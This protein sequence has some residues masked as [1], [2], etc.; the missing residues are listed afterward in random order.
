LDPNVTQPGL[1]PTIEDVSPT[2]TAV[3]APRAVTAGG[4]LGLR[5]AVALVVV[6]L[7][8]ATSAAGAWFLAGRSGTS[9]LA[10]WV[11]SD[12]VAYVE[13][14]LDLPGDQRQQLGNFLAHFP[15]FK[16]Q[17]NLDEKIAEA[18]DRAIRGS[19]NDRHDYSTEVQPWFGGEVAASVGPL[20]P[21]SSSASPSSPP[22]MRYLVLVSTHDRAATEAWV[23]KVA[24]EAPT[25]PTTETYKGVT[26]RTVAAGDHG[27]AS[28]AVLDRVLLVGDPASVKAS[29]DTGG[30]AGLAANSHFSAASDRADG[31]HL[32]FGWMNVRAYVDWSMRVA[33]AYGAP[34][35]RIDPALTDFVPGWAVGD[36]RATNGDALTGRAVAPHSSAIPV[37]ARG[38]STLPAH[39][40]S[41][42]LAFLDVHDT[43]TLAKAALDRWRSVP[44][45]TN[46]MKSVDQ[47]LAALGGEDAAIGWLGEAAIAVLP[48]GTGATAGAL[49]AAT[50]RDKAAA[51]A[52]QIRNLLVLGGPSLGLSSRDENHN[53][54]TITILT[55]SAGQDGIAGA[56][57]PS[58]LAFAVRDDLVVAGTPAFVRAVLDTRADASLASI[59]RFTGPLARVGSDSTSVGWVDLAAVRTRIEALVP[60]G[61]DRDR[62]VSDVAPY[63][64][65]LDVVVYGQAS[66]SD[67]DA[68]TVSL[69]VK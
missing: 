50:G 57:L 1:G 4:R 28:V 68:G 21:V 2:G 11:P 13:A 45:M 55:P 60:A 66:A 67:F 16:D 20:P 44:S 36:L 9:T 65:P 46:A 18:L 42:A 52:R 10:G 30:T 43:A 6:A 32:G 15:G 59:A 69:I 25:A 39:V 7:V 17:A 37:V 54:T 49:V 63:L 24:A 61:T 33:A 40:P 29:I 3:V 5:W 47:A 48:D 62:Y 58:E 19:T 56:S 31:D 38:A 26:I 27:Q 53:G 41:T 12:S 8:V 51:F 34:S 14:R 35:T 64:Q 22:T 23:A